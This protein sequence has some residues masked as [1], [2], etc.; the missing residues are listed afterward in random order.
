M[1][2]QMR[3]RDGHP[4]HRPAPSGAALDN[5]TGASGHDTDRQLDR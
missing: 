5:A 1:S 4:Y 3:A 2:P